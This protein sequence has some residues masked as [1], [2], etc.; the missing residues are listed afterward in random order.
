MN[1]G[2][3]LEAAGSAISQYGGDSVEGY[4]AGVDC[5]Q[6]TV[7]NGIPLSAELTKVAGASGLG[8]EEIQDVHLREWV[9]LARTPYTMHNS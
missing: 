3:G 2:H 5:A 7:E 9:L 6:G 8:A 4:E 1:D